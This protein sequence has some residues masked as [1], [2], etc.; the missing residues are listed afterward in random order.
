M[1][2]YVSLIRFTEK[3]TRSL[4]QSTS[5]ARAFNKATAKFGVKVEAQYWTVGAVDGVML[6]DGPDEKAVLHCLT[7]LTSAG[8]VRTETMRALTDAEFEAIA[9]M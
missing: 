4:Q 3:G 8:F 5:R 6:L 1:P 7:L 2:K 9:G